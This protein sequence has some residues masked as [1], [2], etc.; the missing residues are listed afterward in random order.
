MHEDTLEIETLEELPNSISARSFRRRSPE[1][2]QK[3]RTSKRKIIEFTKD[4][5]KIMKANAD[6]QCEIC[7]YEFSDWAHAMDHFRKSH[8]DKSGFIRCCGRKI[9]TKSEM[10][11]HIKWHKDPAIFSCQICGKLLLTKENLTT[12]EATHIPEEDRQF[13]CS[14][15]PKKFGSLFALHNHKRLHKRDFLEPKISCPECP[16]RK[17]KTKAQFRVHWSNC[18]DKSKCEYMCELCSKTYKSKYTLEIHLKSHTNPEKP[19]EC[20]VRLRT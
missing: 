7:S 18:H 3:V 1:S 8:R 16:D 20:Q 2:N 4:D 5:T 10:A 6:M 12:H 15:C 14:L 13:Q 19:I 17:Y 11:D 9:D